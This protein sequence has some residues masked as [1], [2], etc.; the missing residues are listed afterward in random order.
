MTYGNAC[1]AH[2]QGVPVASDGV[3]AAE[4]THCGGIAA[5]ECPNASDYCAFDIATRCGSGDQSGTC[6]P[7]PGG[8]TTQYDPVCGCDGKT[9]GN[10]CDAAMNGVSVQTQGECP[11][12]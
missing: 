10:A 11:T 3:C 12:T 4:P 2:A 1:D 8:C 5:V 9:Y 6:Q 7:K